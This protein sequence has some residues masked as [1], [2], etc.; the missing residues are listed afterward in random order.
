MYREFI[1]IEDCI[2]FNLRFLHYLCAMKWYFF[3][4]FLKFPNEN[5]SLHYGNNKKYL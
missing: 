3:T 1:D 4:F 2:E 5:S